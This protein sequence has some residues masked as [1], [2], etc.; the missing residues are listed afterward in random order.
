M[1]QK[2]TYPLLN[3]EENN[4]SYLQLHQSTIDELGL[5]FTEFSRDSYW[6]PNSDTYYLCSSDQT[7]LRS[8]LTDVQ[9]STRDIELP[10]IPWTW[11]PFEF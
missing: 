4:E 6:E 10:F 1:K 5:R 7:K 8:R 9:L 2:V 3:I 11:E